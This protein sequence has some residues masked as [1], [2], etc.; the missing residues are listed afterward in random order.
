MELSLIDPYTRHPIGTE[1]TGFGA[2]QW[3][4][5]TLKQIG[6]AKEMNYDDAF[7]IEEVFTYL[8]SNLSP[9]MHCRLTIS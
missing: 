2:V 4:V 7:T 9:C 3:D 1:A 5:A 6:V 8:V